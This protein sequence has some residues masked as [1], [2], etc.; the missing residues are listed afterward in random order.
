MMGTVALENDNGNLEYYAV[1]SVI[2]ERLNQ[3][4][5][6]AEVKIYGKLHAVNA[7]KISRPTGQV[8]AKSNV[9]LPSGTT[10]KYNIA[11]FLQYVNQ[12]FD[13]TFSMDVYNH[14]KV[15]R[16]NN[17]FSKNL[18]FSHKDGVQNKKLANYTKLKVYPKTE[19]IINSIV[20]AN[21]GLDSVLINVSGKTKAE[22]ERVVK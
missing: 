1:R 16:K 14:F 8:I 6:L 17:D 19:R 13:D 4:P 7:K 3:N 15:A 22:A 12:I 11:D 20:E 5:I 21:L 2:E 10:Y 9:A 18:R